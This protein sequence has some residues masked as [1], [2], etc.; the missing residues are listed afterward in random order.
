VA[1][2]DTNGN[3]TVGATSNNWKIKMTT[4]RLSRRGYLAPQNNALTAFAGSGSVTGANIGLYKGNGLFYGQVTISNSPVPNVTIVANDSQQLFDSKGYT[5]VNGNYGVVTL[6]STNAFGTNSVTW[7]AAPDISDESGAMVGVFADDI[8]SDVNNVDF[9]SGQSVLENFIGL[10]VTTNISGQLV[11]NEGAPLSGVSVG[12]NATI[13]G[14]EFTT[15]YVTT[16]NNGDFSF[17]AA[18]G[19]WNVN[20]N[21][22]GSDGLDDLGY[23]DPANYHVVNIPPD[24]PLQ[25]V[26]YPA[27]IPILGQP[28]KISPSQ[29]NFNL[30]GVDGD[31][32]TI[33]ANTNLATTNWATLTT[34]T[35]LPGSPYLIQ[36]FQATN[37]TRFYRAFESQ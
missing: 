28:G 9:N 29:F 30:Y 8:F 32:Y 20:A 21:C 18:N 16:D 25:I 7:F 12:A 34:V 37:T 11:N 19:V 3:Y 5:D 35:N 27:N 6:V 13:D 4:E 15:A 23:Y 1:F 10:P 31:N 24:N 14:N 17:G 33:Q 26:V 22:C 36:D 2:T